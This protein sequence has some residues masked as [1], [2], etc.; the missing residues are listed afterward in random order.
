MALP[1]RKSTS[2]AMALLLTQLSRR[3]LEESICLSRQFWYDNVTHKVWWDLDS[4]LQQ[5]RMSCSKVQKRSHW[6]EVLRERVSADLGND[7]VF[8]HVSRQDMPS[9]MLNKCVCTTQALHTFVFVTVDECKN[10][11]EAIFMT[12]T[13]AGIIHHCAV[14]AMKTAEDSVL[15]I[16]ASSLQIDKGGQ[17][18]GFLQCLQKLHKNV[19]PTVVAAWGSQHNDGVLSSPIMRESLSLLDVATFAMT[20]G[21]RRRQSGRPPSRVCAIFLEWCDE[22]WWPGAPN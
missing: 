16:G 12:K 22:H 14:S 6:I 11:E 21:R 7:I 10:E 1:P 4:T 15:A 2:L 13:F 19:Y 9:H 3:T 18:I 17:V 8:L 20:F 5:L